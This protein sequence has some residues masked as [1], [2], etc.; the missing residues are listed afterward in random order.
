MAVNL[1]LMTDADIDQVCAIQQE[2]YVPDMVEARAV[3]HGRLAACG[4]TCWV[5]EDEYGLCAYLFAYR[6]LH[7]LVSPLGY[8][9]R[10]A[11]DADSL[12]L[13]DLAVS[14]RVAGQGVGA[15]L[16]RLALQ[17]ALACGL[18]YS[19]LV[20]VQSSKVFWNRLGYQ[21]QDVADQAQRASL[22]SYTGPAWYM[23][24]AL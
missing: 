22:D 15:L 12:Y 9:F 20:S 5:A 3:L 11:Q 14:Q 6:S 2:A 13:H 8:A 16:V 24:R 18:R 23:V 17:Q 19:C 4:G 7:G 1:R 21:E 10:H